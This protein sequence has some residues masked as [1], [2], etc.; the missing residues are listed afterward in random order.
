MNQPLPA[1]DELYEVIRSVDGVTAVYPARPAWQNIAGAALSAVTGVQLPP[2]LVL[3]GAEAPGTTAEVRTRIGVSSA[4]RAPDVCRDVAA[5]VRRHLDPLTV[6]VN[7][8]VAA[9]SGP[10]PLPR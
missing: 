4:H 1:A 6:T 8:Q 9:I 10:L 5:A 2:V 3:P 7:V